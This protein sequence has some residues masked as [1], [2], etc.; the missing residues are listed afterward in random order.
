MLSPTTVL[1]QDIW[2]AAYG[3]WLSILFRD[4]LAG[5]YDGTD[6]ELDAWATALAVDSVVAYRRGPGK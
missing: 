4:R 5:R 6:A 2:R 3:L 1:E